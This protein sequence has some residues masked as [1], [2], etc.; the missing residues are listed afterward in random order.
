MT[1]KSASELR[2]EIRDG[3]D[4]YMRNHY[5]KI[6]L[7]FLASLPVP[8]ST[9]DRM[10]RE[11]KSRLAVSLEANAN[12]ELIQ[13]KK[14]WARTDDLL[15]NW[16]YRDYMREQVTATAKAL[17]KLNFP[18]T[19][20]SMTD[21]VNALK[22]LKTTQREVVE[23]L[24]DVSMQKMALN[25]TFGKLGGRHPLDH[26]EFISPVKD[27]P[28]FKPVI[29]PLYRYDIDGTEHIVATPSYKMPEKASKFGRWVEDT[30]TPGQKVW[31][32]DRPDLAEPHPALESAQSYWHRAW[33]KLQLN[34]CY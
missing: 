9:I 34:S 22:K 12:Y 21:Y 11:A 26:Y 5:A 6:Q 13:M 10:V 19:T 3:Y 17:S 4:N 15:R 32:D 1:N 30:T 31:Q 23:Q 25:S 20:K 27:A 29:A 24:R 18:A 14:S 7:N 28:K 2:K 8:E 16:Q 33:A